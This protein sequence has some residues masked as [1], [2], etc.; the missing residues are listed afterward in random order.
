MSQQVNQQRERLKLL[1]AIERLQEGPM[2]FLGFVWLLL[3][4]IEFVWKL[5]KALEY[6]SLFIWVLF[7]I[8]LLIRLILAPAPPL[9]LAFFGRD[10][11]EQD[12]PVASSQSISIL[13]KQ[14][15]E[16]HAN[17]QELNRKLDQKA[18]RS[19]IPVCLP[20]DI[21]HKSYIKCTIVLS[22]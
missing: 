12:A 18:E 2:I 21:H 10:A 8:D 13:Q 20:G 3:L 6:I 5:P 19:L 16:L 11:E 9:W 15:S 1:I 4:I 7:I 22:P 17:I 14:L